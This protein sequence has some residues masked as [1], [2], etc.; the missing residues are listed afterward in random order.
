VPVPRQ[1]R[2]P[3]TR[4]AAAAVLLLVGGGCS[5]APAPGPA[6]ADPELALAFDGLRVTRAEL[7]D[8]VPYFESIDR[9]LGRKHLLRQILEQDVIPLRLAQRDLARERAPLR[10]RAQALHRVVGTGG[11]PE[12][13]VKGRPYGV[14]RPEQGWLRSELPHAVARHA[15]D[16][17]RLGQLSPVLELP[18]GYALVATSE[19]RPGATTALDRADACLVT[20][21]THDA[22]AFGRWLDGARRKLHTTL[23]WVSPDLA[24]VVP[25]YLRP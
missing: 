13:V 16:E 18:Q 23:T 19:I 25:D 24:D 10:E 12:L 11:F 22:A 15:F 8:L 21:Y 20:F 3:L 2:P 17:A 4:G 7:M 1:L 9:R 5:R 6:P 14:H